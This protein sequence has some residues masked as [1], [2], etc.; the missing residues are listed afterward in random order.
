MTVTDHI[1]PAHILYCVRVYHFGLFSFRGLN[2]GGKQKGAALVN[3][4]RV[5]E[6]FSVSVC[7]VYVCMCMGGCMCI[8][9][10]CVS[11]LSRVVV[12]GDKG[13]LADG[14]GHCFFPDFD[15]DG[16]S[17]LSECRIHVTHGNVLFQA[18][19]GAAAGHLT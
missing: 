19:G 2:A 10:V 16:C 6:W 9:R 15:L 14:G 17:V 1:K 3:M 13:H 18:G 12:G 8:L 11:L 5:E 4:D 7:I